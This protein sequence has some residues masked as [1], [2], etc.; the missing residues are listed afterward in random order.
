MSFIWRRHNYWWR[1]AQL[2]PMLAAQWHWAER[3]ICCAIPAVT[4]D[5]IFPCLIRRTAEFSRLLRRTRG[6]EKSILTRILTDRLHA[7]NIRYNK[8]HVVTG[9]KHSVF[10][11]HVWWPLRQLLPLELYFFS[12]NIKTCKL[13]VVKKRNEIEYKWHLTWK[14]CHGQR[15]R[16]SKLYEHIF[17][18]YFT[19]WHI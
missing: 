1:A 11:L 19:E 3:N 17:Y 7:W 4:W 14:I 5:F 15:S 2:R 10:V 9:W 18:N 12:E 13:F 6:C 16:S 8:I